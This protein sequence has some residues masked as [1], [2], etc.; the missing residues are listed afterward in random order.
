MRPG[1]TQRWQH[2]LRLI[3]LCCVVYLTVFSLLTNWNSSSSSF[4]IC[5]LITVI[6]GLSIS[7]VVG[8]FIENSLLMLLFPLESTMS[9]VPVAIDEFRLGVTER[10]VF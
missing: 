4:R 5:L 2:L 3:W 6:C 8:R 7:L 10:I 1:I 9:R